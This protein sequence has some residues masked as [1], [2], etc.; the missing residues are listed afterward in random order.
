MPH[1]KAVTLT[2][3]DSFDLPISFLKSDPLQV[4][5]ALLLADA[6]LEA[7]T[8][9]NHNTDIK[10]LREKIKQLESTTVESSRE[11][12]LRIARAELKAEV[13]G[14][15]AVSMEL[16]ERL[17]DLKHEKQALNEKLSQRESELQQERSKVGELQEKLQQRIAIQSNSSKRGQEGEK[18]FQLLTSNLKGWNLESVGKTKESTDFRASIH[19]VDVRFEVKNHETEVPYTKNVDKFERDMKVHPETKVGVFVALTARIEKLDDTIQIRWTENQQL[20]LFIPYFLTR[21]LTYTYDMIENLIRMMRYL[22]HFFETK[23]T[24]KDIELL[25][26]KID[27]TIQ[28]IQLMDKQVTTMLK[29]HQEYTVKTTA[30]Y[31]GLR[32]FIL[33][34][35]A[36]LT[37]KEQEVPKKKRQSK[38]KSE[39]PT[40]E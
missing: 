27:T 3:R 36:N 2:V 20:L 25:R 29:D 19:T 26:D 9:F 39:E 30:S 31:Q 15:K 23:D 12:A 33:S 28:Q 17:T 21:D 37:G 6:L 34:L 16:R 11:E 8:H 24:T 35:L 1:T 40:S 14:E 7:G 32:S 4:E 22:R 5:R 38:K 10:Q 13:N 18:D